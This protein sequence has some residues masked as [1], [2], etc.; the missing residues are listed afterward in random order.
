M[1][2][3]KPIYCDQCGLKLRERACPKCNPDKIITI[4]EVTDEFKIEAFG[5]L[6]EMC[7]THMKGVT[8]PTED[9]SCQF[10]C[11]CHNYIFEE[12]MQLCLRKDIFTLLRKYES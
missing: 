7:L 10:E 1:S 9:S 11:D 3:K 4:P 5:K 8:D 12:V 6:K 2:T